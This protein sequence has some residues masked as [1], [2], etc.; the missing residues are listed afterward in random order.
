MREGPDGLYRPAPVYW[1]ERPQCLVPV[2][3]QFLPEG[4]LTRAR[5]SQE[6]GGSPATPDTKS[7]GSAGWKLNTLRSRLLDTELLD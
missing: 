4:T 5:P 1:E 2:R 6:K 7:P 3:T